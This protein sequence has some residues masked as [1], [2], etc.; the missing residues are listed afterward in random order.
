LLDPFVND[1]LT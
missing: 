1:M